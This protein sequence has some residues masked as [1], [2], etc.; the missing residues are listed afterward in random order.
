MELNLSIVVVREP[1]DIACTTIALGL[2]GLHQPLLP[3]C[4]SWT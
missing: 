2:I 4:P 3:V 1:I